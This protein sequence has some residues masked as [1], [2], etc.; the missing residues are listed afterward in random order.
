ML[1]KDREYYIK[2]NAYGEETGAYTLNSKILSRI[3][4]S[5]SGD[6][7]ADI[8]WRKDT[9]R[10]VIYYMHADGT[11]TSQVITTVSTDYTSFL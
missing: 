6:G 4:N 7:I 11:K 10:N 2:V 8:L 9:G 1:E 3:Q 5:F